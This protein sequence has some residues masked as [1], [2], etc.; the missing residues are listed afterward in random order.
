MINTSIVDQ[1]TS[2]GYRII[3]N[4]NYTENSIE[5][6][7]KSMYPYIDDIGKNGTLTGNSKDDTFQ[8]LCSKFCFRPIREEFTKK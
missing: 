7:K 8:I 1:L 6:P 3:P 4:T 2:S 5:C